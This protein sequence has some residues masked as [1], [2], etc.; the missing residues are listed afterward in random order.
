ML[1][2]HP[3]LLFL[4]QPR[5]MAKVKQSWSLWEAEPLCATHGAWNFRT[6]MCK[7]S[8]PGAQHSL[9][10]WGSWCLLSL[11]L[12]RQIWLPISAEEVGEAE[13]GPQEFSAVMGVPQLQLPRSLF[14]YIVVPGEEGWACNQSRL[15]GGGAS[16]IGSQTPIGF[17]CE[18]VGRV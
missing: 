11:P 17:S 2:V 7:S 5:S 9:L 15:P 12:S 8:V 10:L 6:L 13:Q 14:L 4:W 16:Y 1:P 18:P 3:N